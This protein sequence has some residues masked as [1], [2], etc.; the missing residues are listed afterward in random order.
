MSSR[1]NI[2]VVL[3]SL[4]ACVSTDVQAAGQSRDVI[5]TQQKHKEVDSFQACLDLR[6][7]LHDKERS[8]ALLRNQVLIHDILKQRELRQEMMQHPHFIRQMMQVVEMR[9]E[10]LKNE[11]MM[12]DMLRNRDTLLEVNRNREMMKVIEKNETYRQINQEQQADILEELLLESTVS[13]RP[14]PQS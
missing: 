4:M 5:H 3:L 8:L 9:Q 6:N 1:K 7:A 10:L 11:P 2:F 14:S 13:S 12:L